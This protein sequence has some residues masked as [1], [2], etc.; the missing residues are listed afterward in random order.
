LF[1]RIPRRWFRPTWSWDIDLMAQVVK[2]KYIAALL[3]EE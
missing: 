3:W 1:A 2:F